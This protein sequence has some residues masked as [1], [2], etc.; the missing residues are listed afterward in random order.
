MARR[1]LLHVGCPKTGTSFLQGVL[2]NNRRALEA[3][4]LSVPA[5]Q[6]H[7]YRAALFVRDAWKQRPAAAEISANW[8]EL[9]EMVHGTD[10]D[11]LITHEV[12]AAATQEQAGFAIDAFGGAETHVVVTAR[13]LARQLPAEWQQSVKQ[14]AVHRLDDFVQ[15]VVVH[16][17]QRAE[18]FWRVQD[19]PAI[20][21]RWGA[22]LPA[23]R[24]HVVTV[25]PQGT[26]P[27]LL[28]TRF[29]SVAGI[30]P[31][32]VDLHQTRSNESLG[33]VEVELLRR[34]N[35]GRGDRFPIMGNHR[36]FKDLLA[37]QIL[38]RR[39]DKDRFVVA[40]EAHQWIC[41]T[42][43]QMVES[44]REQDFDVAGALEDLIP[45][46]TA[47][48]G[49][50]PDRVGEQDLLHAATDT[51]LDLLDVHRA[52]VGRLEQWRD[53]AETR[54]ERIAELERDPAERD[55]RAG[56]RRLLGRVRRK[57]LRRQV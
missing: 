22:E 56:G 41:D 46:P 6:M 5:T 48:R 11:V 55:V 25:P 44:L 14:G 30:D 7:H 24:M 26:D 23:D 50:D 8:D 54:G 4:G 29:A 52:S 38:A 13:D 43:R 47:E 28:W 32:S 51:V 49:S 2:W 31:E 57:V 37:N 27:S 40:E 21:Q 33:S 34:L 15:D 42:S 53:L 20:V 39:T 18:W 10:Q 12:F 36:W 3:Q 19:L 45:P 17:G 9:L 35:E 1:V 16:R